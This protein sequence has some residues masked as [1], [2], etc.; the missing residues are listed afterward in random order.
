MKENDI[1]FGPFVETAVDCKLGLLETHSNQMDN[2]LSE[3]AKESFPI[4]LDN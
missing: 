2:V 1:V 3:K 4:P